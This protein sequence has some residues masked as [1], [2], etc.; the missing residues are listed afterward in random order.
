MSFTTGKRIVKTLERND[1]SNNHLRMI[2]FRKAVPT[3]S[4]HG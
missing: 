4:D 1:E 3:L 2:L